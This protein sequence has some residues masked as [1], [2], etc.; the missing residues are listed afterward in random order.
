MNRSKQILYSLPEYTLLLAFAVTFICDLIFAGK[1]NYSFLIL[2]SAVVAL[3]IWK[4]RLLAGLYSAVLGLGSIYM[5]LALISEYSEFPTGDP[6][7]LNMLL[8][9]SLFF[10]CALSIAIA[11]AIKYLLLPTTSQ[12]T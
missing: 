3:L 10:L 12:T 2:S 11:L 4:S 5:M 9:G 7:G 1:F 6:Q 8:T